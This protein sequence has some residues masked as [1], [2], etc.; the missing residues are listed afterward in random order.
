MY[1]YGLDN[2]E[3]FIFSFCYKPFKESE[4]S[5]ANIATFKQHM[6]IMKKQFKLYN[7]DLNYKNYCYYLD[8]NYKNMPKANEGSKGS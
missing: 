6:C 2:M 7:I 5:W 8:L 3:L 4:F 1:S